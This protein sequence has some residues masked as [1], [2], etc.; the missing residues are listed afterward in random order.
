MPPKFYSCVLPPLVVIHCFKLLSYAI[1]EKTNE[2]NLRKWRKTRFQARFGQFGPIFGPKNGE[3]PHFGP[4]LRQDP[5]P[6]HN[7]FFSFFFFLIWLSQSIDFM[8][9]YHYV[10]YQKKLMIQPWENLVKDGRVDRR[11]DRQMAESDF[12][13]RCPT[14]SVHK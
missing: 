9:N 1:W 2:P 11:A 4:E 5:N 13:G 3:K 10:E 6:G 8:G 12:I 14:M 7:F